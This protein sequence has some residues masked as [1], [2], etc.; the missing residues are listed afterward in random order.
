MIQLR[1]RLPAGKRII[2]ISAHYRFDQVTGT[3]EL[4][5][6]AGSLDFVARTS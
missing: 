1:L 6:R 4:P 2:G 3:I 5:P